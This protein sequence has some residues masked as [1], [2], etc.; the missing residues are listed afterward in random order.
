LQQNLPKG[1]VGGASLTGD[2]ALTIY[3]L[4]Y[5][6]ALFVAACV[7][8]LKLAKK[9]ERYG[10]KAWIEATKKRLHHNV[11]A[12]ALANKLAASLGRFSITGAPS[13]TT[14]PAALPRASAQQRPDLLWHAPGA[15]DGQCDRASRY[16]AVCTAFGLKCFSFGI[17]SRASSSIEW[18]QACGFSA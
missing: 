7:V 11:L 17:T 13:S 4:R 12:I 2:P 15:G 18:R 8:L 14:R 9:W 3:P 10:L 6:R 5:L 16:A 1:D